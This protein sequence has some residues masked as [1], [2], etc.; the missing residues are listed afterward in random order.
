MMLSLL[1]LQA[2][3]TS[4]FLV[5]FQSRE[6]I[7]SKTVTSMLATKYVGDNKKMLVTV[8]AILVTNVHNRR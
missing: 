4:E 5:K 7:T 1:R 8:L 2:L 6:K 3:P